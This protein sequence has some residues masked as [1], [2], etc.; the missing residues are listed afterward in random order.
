MVIELAATHATRAFVGSF[1][2]QLALLQTRMVQYQTVSSFCM[3]LNVV[4]N[5]LVSV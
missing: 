2:T 1:D 3:Y 4:C 5:Q